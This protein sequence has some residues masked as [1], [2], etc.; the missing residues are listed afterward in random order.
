M[1][2]AAKG[3]TDAAARLAAYQEIQKKIMADAPWAPFRHQD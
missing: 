1:A 3:E 2:A